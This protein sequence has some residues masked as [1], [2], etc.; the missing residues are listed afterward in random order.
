MRSVIHVLSLNGLGILVEDSLT[1]P[2]PFKVYFQ[3]NGLG[4]LV[5]DSLT[6][7][8]PFK[9]Y[10]QGNGLGILVEDCLTK[11]AP[12]KVYF[13]GIVCQMF[14]MYGISTHIWLKFTVFM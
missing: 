1:K 7:P 10:F 14:P 13:Q 3:G 8:A 2:A 11:P 12:F 5:E 9:V 6:K 4:I